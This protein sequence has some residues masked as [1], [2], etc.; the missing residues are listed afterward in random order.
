[1]ARATGLLLSSEMPMGARQQREHEPTAA[2]LAPQRH[3]HQRLLAGRH[4]S[5]DL[6]SQQPAPPSA[7]LVDLGTALRWARGALI[8]RTHARGRPWAKAACAMAR[9]SY[10]HSASNARLT[11]ALDMVEPPA[12]STMPLRL[13]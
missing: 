4:R 6:R 8:D 10:G 3:R 7:R 2:L 12:P 9:G 5:R 13:P 11:S 1:T